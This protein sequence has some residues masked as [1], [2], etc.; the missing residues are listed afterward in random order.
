MGEREE[1]GELEKKGKKEKKKKKKDGE[2]KRE[3]IAKKE[4]LVFSTS[5]NMLIADGSPDVT[6]TPKL[7]SNLSFPVKFSFLLF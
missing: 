4:C 2:K 6:Q 3:N 5:R 7:N 1:K